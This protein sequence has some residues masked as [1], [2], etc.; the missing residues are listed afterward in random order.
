M[1]LMKIPPVLNRQN[2][3][4]RVDRARFFEQL[5]RPDISL[6]EIVRFYIGFDG[7]LFNDQIAMFR[8]TIHEL[9]TKLDGRLK[10]DF[11]INDLIGPNLEIN[12]A[13]LSGKYPA[14][15]GLYFDS[16]KSEPIDKFE[17][18][19][20][21]DYEPS[22][23]K[24]PDGIV[25]RSSTAR[26]PALI[27]VKLP[28]SM[29]FVGPHQFQLFNPNRNV[30]FPEYSN[31]IYSRDILN[32]DRLT[33]DKRIILVQDYADGSNF[34]HFLYDWTTK[35]VHFIRSGLFDKVRDVFLLGGQ[36]THFHKLILDALC[37][38]FDLELS[39][40][41]FPE[42]RVIIDSSND[43]YVFADQKSGSLHPA[44][45][46][47]PSSLEMLL[48]VRNEIAAPT[49]SIEKLFVSRA[50]ASLRTITNEDRLREIAKNAGFHIV[51][52]SEKTALEQISLVQNAKCV[53]GAHGMALTALAF[54]N[55]NVS[56][57]ELFHPRIGTDAYYVIGRPLNQKYRFLIGEDTDIR[58]AG[59]RIDEK[60]F[61]AALNAL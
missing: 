54:N 16:A 21:S 6:G 23:L 34:A 60:E 14:L 59:Y 31:R 46:A 37:K 3:I 57:L 1:L 27:S 15:D 42:K 8:E 49:C 44:Q 12:A 18:L 55:N 41:L 11:D 17:L 48:A 53:V 22:N 47:H 9:S 51:K 40:F 61:E 58:T 33:T 29:I 7:P 19:P 13:L 43:I 45:I 28:P 39:H 35:I 38:M 30:C 5:R 20:A 52:M 26:R 24:F 50:D 25:Q 36:P 10:E 2:E 32:Y 4:V 56:V